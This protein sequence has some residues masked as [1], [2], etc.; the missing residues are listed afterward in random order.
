MSKIDDAIEAL[1]DYQQA[2]MEGVM[3]LASRQA[4]HEVCD[5]LRR[6]SERCEERFKQMEERELLGS[7]IAQAM[8]DQMKARAEAAD[9]RL[10]DALE[11]IKHIAEAPDEENE[12]D[13]TEKFRKVRGSCRLFT[14][15][16]SGSTDGRNG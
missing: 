4:I 3:V 14:A 9:A 13:G 7:D 1:L 15:H 5:A 8:V 2:D 16:V 6:S 12:W 10:A 11:V